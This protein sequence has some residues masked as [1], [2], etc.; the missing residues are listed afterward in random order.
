MNPILIPE[1]PPDRCVQCLSLPL[2]NPA[3]NTILAKLAAEGTPVI[4][5]QQGVGAA[6]SG[7]QLFVV[8]LAPMP[9]QETP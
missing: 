6:R 2:G 7:P 1:L 8:Y 3:T 4:A 5:M 9:H